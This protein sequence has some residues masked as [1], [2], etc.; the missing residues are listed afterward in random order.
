MRYHDQI[1]PSPDVRLDLPPA[2]QAKAESAGCQIGSPPRSGRKRRR[3]DLPRARG[4]SAGDWTS[5]P[6]LSSGESA[7][8]W[9]SPV[10]KARCQIG[11]PPR[12]PVAKAQEIGT[13]PHS[14]VVKAQKIG[15]PPSPAVPYVF[16]SAFK[17]RPPPPPPA[18]ETQTDKFKYRCL[19]NDL[20]VPY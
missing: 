2:L 6:P 5:P 12:S 11:P 1:L 17:P 15:L 13:S 14:P 18:V 20:L 9:T 7:G 10:A 3:L 4:E 19:F 16:L 8:D